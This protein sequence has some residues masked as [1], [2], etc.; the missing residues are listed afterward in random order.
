MIKLGAPPKKLVLGIPLYGRTFILEDPSAISSNK[1]PKLGSPA[2][3]LGFSG[4]FT[5]ETGFMGYNEVSLNLV[6]SSVM[7]FNSL[8]YC[9]NFIHCYT[10]CHMYYLFFHVYFAVQKSILNINNKLIQY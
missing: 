1:K 8:C 7:F 9:L 5:R 4:P 3:N 6:F 10:F 2:G